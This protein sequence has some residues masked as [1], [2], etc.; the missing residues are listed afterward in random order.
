M[1]SV[2][3]RT[4]N[5]GKTIQKCLEYLSKQTLLPNEVIIVDSG[6]TDETLDIVNDYKC[7]VINYPKTEQFNYS[8]AINI[9]VEKAKNTFILILSSHVFLVHRNSLEY[10]L[11]FLNEN[12]LACAVSSY[13]KDEKYMTYRKVLKF[14]DIIWKPVSIINFP[15]AVMSNA[16]ALIKREYWEEYPFRED[17]PRAE[18]QD[19]VYY[20]MKNNNL[21]HISIYNP[22]IE[23]HN[24]YFNS[25]KENLDYIT[26]GR[27]I[28][29][30]Y[31]TF[32]RIR[33]YIK[34]AILYFFKG[35]FSKASSSFILAYYITR[36]LLGFGIK[37]ST[38]YNKKLG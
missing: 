21:G 19:W 13:A 24:P 34:K 26:I 7:A 14:K 36:E 15:G 27:Y 25:K 17:I 1:I 12:R 10:M 37:L 9:G 3:I 2:I 33:Y 22:Y 28:Y 29:P 31:F 11:A 8:K 30:K 5:S 23:Y 38:S 4:K 18:D 6:S 16:C 32:G 20:H 35:E